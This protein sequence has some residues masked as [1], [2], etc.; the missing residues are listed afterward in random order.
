MKGHTKNKNY[1]AEYRR[2]NIV[3][4]CGFLQWQIQ[5]ITFMFSIAHI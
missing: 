4:L 2:Y 3:I 1:A 5:C